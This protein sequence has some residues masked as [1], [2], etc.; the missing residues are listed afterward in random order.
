LRLEVAIRTRAGDFNLAADFEAPVGITTL[1][2]P[3]G[4]GK[5]LTLRCIAGLNRPDG[6]RIGLR[7]RI[8]FDSE[9]G[10]DLPTR[11]RRVGY[12]FQQYA[13]FP[14]LNVLGNVTF[15]LDGRADERGARAA[16][17]LRLVGLTDYERRRPRDLSGGEQQRV[18]L[19]R[20]LAPA[21]EL[22]L[23]DEPLSALDDRVRRR[24]RTELR[25]VHEVTQVPMVIVTHNQAEMRELSDWVV[26]YDAGRVL[27]SGPTDEVLRDPGS[28][29]AAD[30][31]AE[32]NR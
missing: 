7:G 22:L 25:R 9:T 12:L 26:L 23:L 31:L 18:A 14:H 29:E 3:S 20:A 19:A 13:L 10:V 4:A 5:T 28:A 1:F 8:L 30:L 24:L 17:L 2:G 21:P 15:G 6:G 32:V 27:R 11:L 16:E